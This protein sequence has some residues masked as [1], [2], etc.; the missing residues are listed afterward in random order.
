VSLLLHLEPPLA[1]CSSTQD[2]C[3]ALAE[4]GAGEGTAVRALEQMAGRGRGERSWHSP[5]GRGLWMSFL[6]RP[7][8]EPAAWPALTGLTAL[9]AAGALEAFAPRSWHCAIKWPNDLQGDLGKLGGILAETAGN[10]VV[11]GLGINLSQRATDFAPEIRS[12]ASSLL[13]EGFDPVPDPADLAQRFNEVLTAAYGRF[14][15]GDRGFL[16]EGLRDRF[17]LRG[18]RV[19]IARAGLPAEG[20]ARDIGSLGELVLETPSGVRTVMSGEVQ[21]I[22]G[23]PVVGGGEI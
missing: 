20:V 11:I 1:A 23:P 5:P 2:L 3:R 10:A 9:S 19:R 15:A 12:R 6:L 17:Y 7:S 18:A 22:E 8:F 4:S 14:S 21:A 16:R 13:L